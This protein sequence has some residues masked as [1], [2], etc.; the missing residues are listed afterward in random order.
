MAGWDD[1]RTSALEGLV[2]RRRPAEDR[3]AAAK[4][5][6]DRTTQELLGSLLIE[7]QRVN[8]EMEDEVI[9]AAVLNLREKF[10]RHACTRRAV[11]DLLCEHQ[12]HWKDVAMLRHMLM[13]MGLPGDLGTLPLAYANREAKERKERRDD[14]QDQERASPAR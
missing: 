10:N 5:A 4:A 1:D 8:H 11:S 13:V 6:A 2:E 12:D 3:A 14:G 7:Y 9:A